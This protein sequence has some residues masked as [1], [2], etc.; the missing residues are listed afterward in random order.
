M[1]AAAV[2]QAIQFRVPVLRV[3]NSGHSLFLRSSGRIPPQHVTADSQRAVLVV[4]LTTV[5]SG[6]LRFYPGQVF[7]CV[8]FAIWMEQYGP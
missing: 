6:S 4:E 1:V 8:L 7:T 5:A 2:F 3:S